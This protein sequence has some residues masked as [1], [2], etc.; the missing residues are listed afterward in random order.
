M[1]GSVA[2]VTGASRGIGAE[3]AR[4]FAAAGAQVVIAARSTSGQPGRLAG[5]LEETAAAIRAEGGEVLAV[6]TDLSQPGDRERLVD[7]A[8]RAFGRVDVLVNNAAITYFVP[9]ADFDLSRPHLMFEIQV[10]ASMHLSQLV[11]P[12]MRERGRGW[13]CNITSDVAGHPRVPPSR[14]GTKG[15]TTVYGMCKAAVERLSTGLAAE[16]YND[17]IAVNALGPSKV[18]PTPGTVFH[19]VTSE[20]DPNSEGPEVMAAAALALCSGDPKVLSGRIVHS[21]DLLA[22]LAEQGPESKETAD[23]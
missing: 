9:V 14:W 3:I 17:G 7:E 11:L 19:G 2:I 8:L 18:V 16:V 22:E 6:P 20:G 12:G 4:S 15:T 21:Q 13:I 5:T 23:A 10:H 1:E